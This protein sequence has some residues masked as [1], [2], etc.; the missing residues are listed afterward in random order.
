MAVF[1]SIMNYFFILPAYA[2]FMNLNFGDAKQLIATGILPFNII[3]GILVAIVFVLLFG[4]LQNWLTK[5][6]PVKQ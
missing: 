6:V 1:M 3:K 4:K 5:L 2:L